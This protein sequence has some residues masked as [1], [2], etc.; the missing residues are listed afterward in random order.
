MHLKPVKP[1]RSLSLDDEDAHRPKKVPSGDALD[2]ALKDQVDCLGE[3]Q[4]V[5]YAD[6]RYALLVV[7]QG[8][9]AAGKDGTSAA[10][11]RRSTRKAASSRASSSRHPSSSSTTS[12]GASTR[13]S[14]G[15]GCSASS[16]APITRTC[17]R[18]ACTSS[19]PRPC[20]RSAMTRSTTSSAY[21]LPATS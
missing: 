5:F 13:L 16:T 19:C 7:L 18:S 6:A 12:C 17:L 10:Y 3:L 2:A 20:G 1:K 11:S 8:R 15:G 4:R 9:D 14:R 21:S